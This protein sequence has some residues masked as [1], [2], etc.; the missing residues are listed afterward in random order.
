MRR[1][2]HRTASVWA[3]E[4]GVD[5]LKNSKKQLDAIAAELNGGQNWLEIRRT[6]AAKP[7]G[8][9]R[10]LSKELAEKEGGRAKE[11]FAARAKLL[12]QITE[13][14]QF[15]YERQCKELAG[16]QVG[17]DKE[18]VDPSRLLSVIDQAKKSLD[19]ITGA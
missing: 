9:V 6:I 19:V 13:L 18:R 14:D 8:N 5:G 16:Y 7:L 17:P 15:A 2:R 10:A 11:I 12:V 4:E 1:P 3:S